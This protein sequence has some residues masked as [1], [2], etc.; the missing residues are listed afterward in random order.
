MLDMTRS[1]STP[2]LAVAALALGALSFLG[3]G[4]IG[5]LWKGPAPVSTI[6]LAREPVPVPRVEVPALDGRSIASVGWRGSVT[7]VNFW[8]TWCAPC[9]EEAAQFQALL[10]RYPGR[11]RVVA[12]SVDDGG[13]AAVRAWVADQG[14]RYPVG[15]ADAALQAR[16]GGIEALPTTFVVDTE[17]RIVQRHVGLYPP[18][19][20]DLEVRALLGEPVDALVERVD[21]ELGVGGTPAR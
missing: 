18:L 10:E 19:V 4:A 20:Y 17:G 3:G 6:R 13:P 2:A 11:L 14:V 21:L 1:W 12:L 8:A 7:L 5:R 9:R 15:M 16:F